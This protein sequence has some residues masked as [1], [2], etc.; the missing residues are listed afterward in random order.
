[1]KFLSLALPVFLACTSTSA[2]RVSYDNTYDSSSGSLST[3]ACSDGSNGLLTKGFTTF[4]SLPH[5]PNIGGAQAVASW[6]SPNCGSCWNLTFKGTS[7]S[8][9]AVDHADSGFN[10]AQAA[11]DKLTKNQAVALGA[12]DATATQVSKSVCGLH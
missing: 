11:M 3:V 12:I 10:I 9:L 2:I 6:N 7:I 8:V 1:M 5:F 4:G